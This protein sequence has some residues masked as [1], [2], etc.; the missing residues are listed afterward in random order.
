M[1]V[2]TGADAPPDAVLADA[3]VAESGR[4]HSHFI[5]VGFELAKVVAPAGWRSA[6]AGLRKRRDMESMSLSR[7]ADEHLE[8]ARSARA[9]RSAHTVHGGMTICRGRR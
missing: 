2:A 8:V 3:S 5:Y 9:G 1:L 6:A 4:S 7:L